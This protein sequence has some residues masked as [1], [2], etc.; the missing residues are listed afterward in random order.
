MKGKIIFI[1]MFCIFFGSTIS[2]QTK[3]PIT[4]KSIISRTASI[5]TYYDQKQLKAM[6]KGELLEL[7][8]E[9]IKVLVNTLPY[10]ALATKPGVTMVDVGIPY[11]SENKKSFETQEKGTIDFLEL[12]VEFQ[13]KI[14]PYSD[15]TSLISAILFYESTLKSL[16]EFSDSV[17]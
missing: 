5:K 7:Y 12:T 16:H 8:I 2:A 17:E 11:D 15:K 1:C 13:R 9:R 4:P 10:I 3:N 14:L 6:N